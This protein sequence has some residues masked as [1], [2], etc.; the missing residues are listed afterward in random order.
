MSAL[1]AAD[2]PAI[3]SE[4][5][6]GLKKRLALKK[7]LDKR[8]AEKAEKAKAAAA[9]LSA[10]GPSDGLEAE[11]EATARLAADA[12]ARIEAE[13]AAAG[14]GGGDDDDPAAKKSQT[15]AQY[16]GKDLTVS[17][18][19]E[20]TR[21]EQL[22]IQSKV[23]AGKAAKVKAVVGCEGADQTFDETNL[24]DD[25][26][27][28]FTDCKASTFRVTS[29]CVKIFIERC[30]G[31][32]FRFE[33]RIITSTIEVD[34]C[35]ECNVLCSTK[36]GT[37]QCEQSK[38][39][40]LVYAAKELLGKGWIVWAGCFMLRVQVGEDLMRCDFGLT[41]SVDST[42][43]V[44]RTQFKISYDS[45]GKLVCDKIIRLANGYPTTRAEDEEH[46]RRKEEKLKMMA[47]RMGITIHR[48]G[49]KIK[50]KPNAPCPCG[51]G[52][53]FKKC[54][55][56]KGGGSATVSE[57]MAKKLAE[58]MQQQVRQGDGK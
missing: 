53:K 5:G 45:L 36:V 43:N 56:G 4:E 14:G 55:G 21:D 10:A 26:V 35:E 54:C 18:E 12:A 48:K 7:K 11:A 38:R 23:G 58:D 8:N 50:V 46:T 24:H 16:R 44:E 51:S 31:C 30:H 42:V 33:G 17:T 2:Q 57:G 40:N 41:K 27:I 19:K 49:G 32:T 25:Q 3:Y 20:L 29:H 22:R 52:K 6:R 1:A 47:D 39:M 37:L 34:R 13:A 15:F 9:V 28:V